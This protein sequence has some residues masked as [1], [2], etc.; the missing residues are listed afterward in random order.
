MMSDD[1]RQFYN[2]LTYEERQLYEG[3]M[4]LQSLHAAG[5]GAGSS[6]TAGQ[7]PQ[8]GADDDSM[9][10]DDDSQPSSAAYNPELDENSDLAQGFGELWWESSQQ[11]Q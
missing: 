1:Q 5:Y 4:G 7:M 6:G 2:S 9:L 8:L 10:M 11:H 3:S